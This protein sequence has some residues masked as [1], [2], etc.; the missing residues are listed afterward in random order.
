MTEMK[1]LT[2]GGKTYEIVDAKA[3][4]DMSM[5]YASAIFRTAEGSAIAVNDSS[6][7]ALA[8]LKLFGKTEQAT[9]TGAQLFDCRQLTTMTI[10]G[11]TMVNDGRGIVTLSGTGETA[12]SSNNI[13]A[14][15]L[16]PGTYYVSGMIEGKMFFY[17]RLTLADG[18]YKYIKAP[19]SFTLDG[20][21]RE[22][23]CY[24][25]APQTGI[26]F[27]NDVI[28]PMLN[29][30]DEPLP[31]E[32]YTG[33]APAPN[34]DHPQAL[35]T[36]GDS[37][38]ITTT[39]TGKN[40]LDMSTHHRYKDGH[41]EVPYSAYYGIGSEFDRVPVVPGQTYTYS[42]KFIGGDRIIIKARDKDGKY[43]P[44]PNIGWGEYMAAYDGV[45]GPV[46]DGA[47]FTIPIDSDIAYVS[48]CVCLM[49]EC[50]E[51]NYNIY[52][53]IQLEMGPVATEYE[54]YKEPRTM[55]ISTP[56]GLPGIPVD[57]GGNYTDINGQQWLCDEIDFERGTYIQRVC[58]KTFDGVDGEIVTLYA[59]RS[60]VYGFALKIT[61]VNMLK[62]AHK[63]YCTHFKNL[64]TGI[65]SVNEEC[66]LC[67]AG[68]TT[69]Y[70]MVKKDRIAGYSI[71]AFKS[72][73]NANPI[74]VLF[75][76]AS[77]IETVLSDETVEAYR[78]LRMMYPS[79]TVKNDGNAAMTLKYNADTLAVLNDM[80][81]NTVIDPSD[82][83]KLVDDYFKENPPSG[84]SGKDGFSP[85]VSVTETEGGYEVCITDAKGKH[86]FELLHGS[87]GSGNV[88][89]EAVASA[90]A[91]Y[92]AK[93]YPVR[94][95]EVGLFADK[96]EGTASPYS[97]VVTI[98]G[99][100]PFTQVDLTPSVEQLAIFHD[101]DI[102]FVTEN[103]DG[104]VTVYA[105]GVKPSNDY[106]IQVTLKEVIV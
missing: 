102:A 9:T 16:V 73:L 57:D 86:V 40:L 104:I 67:G 106:T 3:R 99:V 30:G 6:D 82:L 26:T 56:N 49:P 70:V 39:I 5:A 69:I 59:E 103:E 96:W 81:K 24:L 88:S 100:T 7:A 8:E 32:P 34:P 79:T 55:T 17:V 97:Q 45:Y 74:T 85:I 54:P 50:G 14:E 64:I 60:N 18:T 36:I 2:M 80:V 63:A 53:D 23:L 62:P 87:D 71:E 25:Y 90:V 21:E 20:T 29:A 78:D 76:L 92:F 68:S 11:V 51:G 61:D 28:Y 48:L 101:K 35:N 75:Q 4:R 1:T 89:D 98:N 41:L 66:F 58:S 37:G 43:I 95:S 47:T 93:N 84:G 72:W 22:V 65:S 38:S 83:E 19:G 10:K 12:I 46:G 52:S 27:N 105:I 91:S 33:G 42:H 77:P 31:W 13:I 15:G 44:D 94:I